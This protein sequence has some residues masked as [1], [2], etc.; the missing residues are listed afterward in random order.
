MA[1]RSKT[2]ALERKM[3]PQVRHMHEQAKE[4]KQPFSSIKNKKG[5]YQ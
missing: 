2:T 3:H 1:K 4:P 5:G